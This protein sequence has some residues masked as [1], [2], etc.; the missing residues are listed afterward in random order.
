MYE[1]Y[2]KLHL[3]LRRTKKKNIPYPFYRHGLGFSFDY[4]LALILDKSLPY[5][6]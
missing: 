2:K 6:D 3:A 5:K 4:L 1:E